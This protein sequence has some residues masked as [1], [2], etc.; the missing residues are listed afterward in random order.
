[1]STKNLI[2]FDDDN[3]RHLLPLTFVR[4]VSELRIG[5]LTLREK[6]ERLLNAKASYITQDHLADKYPVHLDDDNI[7]INSACLPTE[8]LMGYISK[9]KLNEAILNKEEFIAQSL[10]ARELQVILRANLDKDL[11]DI[12]SKF[13][14]DERQIIFNALPARYTRE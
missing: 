12:A 9:L 10:K 5:I 4:P 11:A 7:L 1:M 13:T 14:Q 6:W 2:L 8:K 3:W